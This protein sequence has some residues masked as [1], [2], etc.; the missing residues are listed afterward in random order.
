MLF[1]DDVVADRKAKTG[2]FAG[3]LRGEKRIENLLLHLGRNAGAV[4]PDP[5]L[6]LVA[7]VSGRGGHGRL[8]AV[9]AL[10]A[11]ALRC[12]IK[13]VG[14]E[15]EQDPRN[16]L[17]EGV[18]RAGGWIERALQGDVEALLLGSR[19]VKGEVEAFLDQRIDVD[20][21]AFACARARMQQ[22]IL[23][24]GVGAFAVVGDL[25]EI[26]AQRGGEI[27]D[28][29]ARLGVGLD[30]LQSLAQLVDQLD[31][32]TGEIVDEVE[33]VLDFVGDA[34]GELAE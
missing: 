18:D 23:D 32:D 11:V 5:D 9:V 16:L 4:V 6:D 19:T 34:G 12:R 17:R 15:V 25:V 2:A 13:A 30:L 28:V 27:G 21:P 14:D 31:G 7:E 1:D 20:R 26:I 24:D 10:L 22:H 29:G 33:R 3:R 8:K